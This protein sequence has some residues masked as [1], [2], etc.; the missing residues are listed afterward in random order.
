MNSPWR[1]VVD[2]VGACRDA[3]ERPAPRT[4]ALVILLGVTALGALTLPR[5]LHLLAASLAP[6]SNAARDF[7]H[8]VLAGGLIRLTVVDRLVPPPTVMVAGA[9]VAWAA[10]SLLGL[11]G[12]ARRRI[13]A[14]AVLG[15]VPLLVQRAGE[16]VVTYAADV[17]LPLVPGSAMG[18]PQEF[19]T[20]PALLWRHDPPRWLLAISQR[21]NLVTAW[22]VVIWAVGLRALDAGRWRAWHLGVPLL[23]LAVAGLL[24]WWFERTALTLILGRP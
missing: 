19:V 10:D 17:P 21:A 5:Q 14:V 23:C 8:Q 2:P 9:L 16:L 1:A 11:A 4:T 13:A 20:G 22:V 15:L 7:H 18:L 3:S 12:D 24:T 6:T